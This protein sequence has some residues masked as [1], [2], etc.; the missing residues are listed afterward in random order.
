MSRR[1][2]L[3]LRFSFLRAR[4]SKSCDGT[5]LY[6]GPDSGDS[7]RFHS[8]PL[9]RLESSVSAFSPQPASAGF[10]FHSAPRQPS[11]CAP[12]NRRTQA[13]LDSSLSL[14]L[15]TLPFRLLAHL[16]RLR[17]SVSLRSH[18]AFG[19]PQMADRSTLGL[20]VRATRERAPACSLVCP[21]APPFAPDCEL[22]IPLE[23]L[24]LET[25][26]LALPRWRSLGKFLKPPLH[27]AF[28]F[29]R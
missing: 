8:A 1:R 16:L 27:S 7:S 14:S 21:I 6:L 15:K 20:S 13:D 9:H 28:W 4:A 29:G 24:R 22:S 12:Q 10:R 3:R 23:R 2:I 11:G 17:Y 26:R 18:C 5:R 19:S 25:R